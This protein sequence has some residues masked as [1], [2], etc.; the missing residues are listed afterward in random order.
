[1]C[2]RDV[3][4][5]K[6]A[7]IVCSFLIDWHGA[8]FQRKTGHKKTAQLSSEVIKT[9]CS[10]RSLRRASVI[11][12]TQGELDPM[13]HTQERS[14]ADS[15][16]YNAGRR[17]LAR[18][19]LVVFSR[20]CTAWS[21]QMKL[22]HIVRAALKHL[23]ASFLSVCRVP[24]SFV[25]G[26]AG[27]DTDESTSKLQHGFGQ[28]ALAPRC[29][30]GRGSVRHDGRGSGDFEHVHG[31]STSGRQRSTISRQRR[32]RGQRKSSSSALT[33]TWAGG[34]WASGASVVRRG[35]LRCLWRVVCAQR[36][37]AAKCRC[38]MTS[39]CARVQIDQAIATL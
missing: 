7:K 23:S 24:H 4:F 6:S 2:F 20:L 31:G 29:R 14:A 35:R 16:R 30:P 15:W 32:C 34:A 11:L 28:H 19:I 26:R 39:A 12:R 27:R 37:T 5:I 9:Q 36:S 10:S 38:A 8:D 13:C 33:A 22:N 21:T 25:C 1:M 17:R 3:Y 18:C